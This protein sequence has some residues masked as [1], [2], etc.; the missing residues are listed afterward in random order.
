MQFVWSNTSAK[1]D[2]HN[3]HHISGLHRQTRL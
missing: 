3:R 1:S 2:G